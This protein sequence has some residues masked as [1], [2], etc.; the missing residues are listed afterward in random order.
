MVVPAL[1]E[2]GLADRRHWREALTL[3]TNTA[4]AR[5]SALRPSCVRRRTGRGATHIPREPCRAGRP[6]HAVRQRRV[7][8]PPSITANRL[9]VPAQATCPRVFR[10]K[11]S[12]KPAAGPRWRRTPR[13]GAQRRQPAAGEVSLR[14]ISAGW[15][16]RGA[17]ARAGPLP[18][19]RSP[20]ST[21][22]GSARGPSRAARSSGSRW[23]GSPPRGCARPARSASARTASATRP[24][25]TG[26]P[27]RR[28][29]GGEV[30]DTWAASNTTPACAGRARASEIPPPGGQAPS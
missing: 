12:S 29:G 7:T 21:G 3:V 27:E 17:K 2:G 26:K 23:C 30:A 14:R 6:A 22:R 16:V 25:A 19:P 28:G 11:A 24:G 13:R 4:S 18:G 8:R 1:G 9:A 10:N 5:R 20:H 15:R